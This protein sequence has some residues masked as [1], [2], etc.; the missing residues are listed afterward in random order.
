MEVLHFWF[1]ED[2]FPLCEMVAS[3]FLLL[4]LLFPVANISMKL[5]IVSLSSIS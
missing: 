5:G 1:W 2:P 4:P 3:F